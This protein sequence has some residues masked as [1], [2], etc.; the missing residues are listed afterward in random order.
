MMGYIYCPSVAG[1]YPID[2]DW[3]ADAIEKLDVFKN[4]ILLATVDHRSKDTLFL[5]LTDI[6]NGQEIGQH[7]VSMLVASNTLPVA[8][9]SPSAGRNNSLI[10]LHHIQCNAPFETF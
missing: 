10:K 9:P 8:I 7:L 4:T 6:N 2:T 5:K 3:S 1:I